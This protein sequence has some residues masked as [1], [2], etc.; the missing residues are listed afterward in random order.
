MVA[1]Q[2]T[3]HGVIKYSSITTRWEVVD[4]YVH[5]TKSNSCFFVQFSTQ[6][7][8]STRVELCDQAEISNSTRAGDFVFETK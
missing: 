6:K 8:I 2:C 7:Y 4:I 1:Q 3:E 5:T